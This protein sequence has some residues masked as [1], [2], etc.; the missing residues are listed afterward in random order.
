MRKYEN[1]LGINKVS[2]RCLLVSLQPTGL[3]FDSDLLLI[4]T[5]L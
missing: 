2:I 1:M 3:V 5:Y 4:F